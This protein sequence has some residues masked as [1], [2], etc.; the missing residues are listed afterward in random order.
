MKKLTLILL[1][2]CAVF[3]QFP[4]ASFAAD[5]LRVLIWSEYMP[6]DY[7]DTFTKETGIKSRVEFYESTE[8]LVA[9]LQAGGVKQYD[10]VVPSDYIINT[11]IKLNLLQKLDHAKLPNLA[12]LEESFKNTAYDPGN[13]YTAPYQWGT[14]GM[15][16]NKEVL[17]ADYVASTALF[18]DPAERKGSVVMIDSIRE[19][20]GIALKYM[21][22]SVNTL[23]KDELKALAKMMIETKSSKY[24]AGFDVGTGGRSK[25]V[26]GTAI[27]AL[28]YNGD[29]LRAVADAPEK[30]VF[31]NPKE[32]GVI[33][34]DNMA[35]PA[36]APHVDYAHTFINWVLDAKNGA[37]LSNWT[38]YATP[39][40]AAKEF[41]TPADMTNPAIY[42]SEETMKT[43]EFINDLGKNNR[44]YD[45]LWTMIKTR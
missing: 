4:A 36:G 8:E 43:L 41:I 2:V 15:L 11:M 37:T 33:W 16:Y 21:G 10:V 32:G 12:N 24:F 13:V 20:L 42:P 38:Q 28:V 25:V 22:K 19:M 26:A 35:I 3:L 17:G 9:K 39:N 1:L 18:F 31:A 7:M 5:E 29:A 6:E 34:A 23:D 45:E 14:V 27:A 40:Q 30:F 44:Y